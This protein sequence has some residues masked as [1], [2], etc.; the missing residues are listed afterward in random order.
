MIFEK[1]INPRMFFEPRYHQTVLSFNRV[2]YVSLVAN[3][4]GRR[5]ITFAGKQNAYLE[6]M[7]LVSLKFANGSKRRY[8]DY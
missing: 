5:E 3:S 4:N 8:A 2:N 7:R 1:H 6:S